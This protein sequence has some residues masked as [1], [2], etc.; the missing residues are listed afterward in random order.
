MREYGIEGA[1]FQMMV[2]APSES[3]LSDTKI[4]EDKLQSGRTPSLPLCALP[5]SNAPEDLT[6]R[7]PYEW[8][9]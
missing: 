3:G 5:P 6:W 7:T 1:R 4:P 2:Y 9:A 8:D